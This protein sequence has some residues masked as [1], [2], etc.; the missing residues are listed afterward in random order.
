MIAAMATQLLMARHF[1]ANHP[2]Q[3]LFGDVFVG[4]GVA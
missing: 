4:Q 1:L 3:R 2:P